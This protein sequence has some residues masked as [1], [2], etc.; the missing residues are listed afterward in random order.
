MERL[1]FRDDGEFDGGGIGAVD[2]DE[3]ADDGTERAAPSLHVGKSEG[4]G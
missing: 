2:G 1:G 3:E 4:N